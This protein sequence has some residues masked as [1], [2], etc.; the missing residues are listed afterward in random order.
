MEFAHP[1]VTMALLRVIEV[2]REAMDKMLNGRFHIGNDENG[3]MFGPPDSVMCRELAR[4]ALAEADEILR[5]L[6]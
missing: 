5:S 3:N 2:Q 6:G 1:S 4:K